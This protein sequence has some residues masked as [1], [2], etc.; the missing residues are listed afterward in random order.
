MW[1]P[2][3]FHPTL[4]QAGGEGAPGSTSPGNTAPGIAPPA[5]GDE[6]VAIQSGGATGTGEQQPSAG[7]QGIFFIMMAVLVGMIVISMMS[8]RKDKK[9]KAQMM[10]AMG[11]GDRVQTIGGI[12]GTV[13]EVRDNDVLLKVDE[14]ANTKIR[15]AKS[16][17]QT[18]LEAKDNKDDQADDDET[19]DAE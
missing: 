15:F 5:A 11:K 8:G 6:G 17:V 14:N 12:L 2:M 18:V 10:S 13:V 9:K 19:K 4:A 1:Q 16:A 7:G 3:M